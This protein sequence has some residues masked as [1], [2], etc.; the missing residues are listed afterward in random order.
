[1]HR[2]S[3]YYLAR[4]S[5]TLAATCRLYSGGNSR[6]APT[7]VPERITVSVAT[8]CCRRRRQSKGSCKGC[9]ILCNTLCHSSWHWDLI[10]STSYL[11]TA[12][13]SNALSVGISFVFVEHFYSVVISSFAL[14]HSQVF[15]RNEN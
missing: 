2:I 7:R 13:V 11:H 15:P 12:L 4:F 10:T 1:M 5:L 6:F 14:R 9:V 8:R 3:I